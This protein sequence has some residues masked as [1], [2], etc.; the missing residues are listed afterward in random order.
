M[1]L[2]LDI[3]GVLLTA[4]PGNGPMGLALKEHVDE[5]LIWATS[6]FDCYWLTGWAPGGYMGMIND[7]LLPHLPPEAQHIS[8]GLW[9]DIKTE[10]LPQDKNWIWIDD[11]LLRNERER[12]EEIG[13]LRNFILVDKLEPS[14][15]H[16]KSRIEYIRQELEHGSNSSL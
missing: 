8:I 11:N 7:K 2:F 15:R 1:R 10:G 13:C 3:D 4:Q 6:Y 12:L 5:F 9:N 16:V 14:L